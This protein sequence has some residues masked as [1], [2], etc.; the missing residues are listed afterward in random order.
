M[1]KAYNRDMQRIVNVTP[2]LDCEDALIFA[3]VFGKDGG[4][5]GIVN[6]VPVD[7]KQKRVRVDLLNA[8]D[9]TQNITVMVH[10]KNQNDRGYLDTVATEPVTIEPGPKEVDITFDSSMFRSFKVTIQGG[11][12]VYAEQIRIESVERVEVP[13][14]V[15]GGP[16]DDPVPVGCN[17]FGVPSGDHYSIVFEAEGVGVIGRDR[18]LIYDEDG[19]QI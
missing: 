3:K 15:T 5:I 14:A 2:S 19:Y 4:L 6:H 1:V 11:E 7:P 13:G 18:L 10:G 8:G 17:F 12:Q 16:A 9:E